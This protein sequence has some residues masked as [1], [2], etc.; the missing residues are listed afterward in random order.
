LEGLGPRDLKRET[1]VR[2]HLEE[3]DE[4]LNLVGEGGTE[5]GDA[6][7]DDA[8]GRAV[9]VRGSETHFGQDMLVGLILGIPFGHYKSE[10]QAIRE[11][12]P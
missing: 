6:I 5:R 3:S 8:D 11:E 2:Q 4:D 1:H 12:D 10:Q 7:L 9:R